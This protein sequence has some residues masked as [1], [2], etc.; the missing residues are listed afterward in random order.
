METAVKT[1]TRR[2]ALEKKAAKH[3]GPK[4]LSKAGEWAKAH[5]QGIIEVLDWRAVNR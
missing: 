3:Q 5:P 2:S 1:A 4:R